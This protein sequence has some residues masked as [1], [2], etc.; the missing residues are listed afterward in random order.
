MVASSTPCGACAAPG[1]ARSQQQHVIRI[2]HRGVGDVAVRGPHRP[3]VERLQAV[4]TRRHVLEPAQ[5]DEAV[6]MV[7]VAELADHAHAQCLL[8]L[9]EFAIEQLDQHVPLARVQR[10][11]AQLDD[12][13]VLRERRGG[14]RGVL[15]G[16][17]LW[18]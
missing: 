6:S 8:R 17:A 4:R 11:L 13:A 1:A 15:H 18:K 14:G 2:D 16:V 10:V 12:F 9:D 5:P 3:A 7:Q